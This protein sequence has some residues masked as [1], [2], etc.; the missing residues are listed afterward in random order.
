[1]P[2]A[3][4]ACLPDDAANGDTLLL[5]DEAAERFLSAWEA[6]EWEPWGSEPVEPTAP[7]APAAAQR[8]A[9]APAPAAPAAPLTPAAAPGKRPAGVFQFE[10]ETVGAGDGAAGWEPPTFTAYPVLPYRSVVCLIAPPKAGKSFVA[11]ELAWAVAG[12]GA[13]LD[14]YAIDEPGAVVYVAGEGAEETAAR[15]EVLRRR[16]NG[17][18][19]HPIH[20]VPHPVN[21]GD[22]PTAEAFAT[23]CRQLAARLVIIDTAARCGAGDEGAGDMGAFVAGI[24]HLDHHTEAT[25]LLLHHTPVAD[26]RR[27][28]GHSSLPAAVDAEW[29][30]SPPNAGGRRTLAQSFGR[31]SASTA[32]AIATF[33]IENHPLARNRHGREIGAGYV[34]LCAEAADSEVPADA[35]AKAAAAVASGKLTVRDAASHFGVP[36]STVQRGAK[37]L[38]EPKNAAS[39]TA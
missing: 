37:K 15:F 27:S 32:D 22:A 7:A 8:A 9:E 28:R 29:V 6:G 38:K 13:F 35:K 4:S 19:L 12:G 36:R 14:R 33:T 25:T 5:D 34:Q 2:A 23:A 26:K 20:V 30:L 24:T 3:V 10:F 21:F 39:P 18:P 16:R 17:L 1:M 11:V 31:A